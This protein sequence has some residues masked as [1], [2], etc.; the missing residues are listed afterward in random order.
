MS[1]SRHGWGGYVG[2]TVPR[3]P[4]VREVMPN[5]ISMAATPATG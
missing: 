3:K 2:I 5:V 1:R 4:F